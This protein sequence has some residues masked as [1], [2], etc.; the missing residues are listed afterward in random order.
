VTASCS[1]PG[2]YF[3]SPSVFPLLLRF[4]LFFL[5]E[6][7]STFFDYWKTTAWSS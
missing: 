3:P 4:L 7:F 5:N 6:F 2:Y 1:R